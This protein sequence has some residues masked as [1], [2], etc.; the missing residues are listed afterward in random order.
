MTARRRRRTGASRAV[1]A[2]TLA[3]VRAAFHPDRLARICALDDFREFA[4]RTDLPPAGG[5]ERFF[6]YRDNGSTVLAVAHLDSVQ[7]D[8]RCTVVDTAAGPL[9]LAPT[10]DDRLGAYVILDL[11]P[12]LGVTAD[13]LLTTDEEIGRSTADAFDPDK[14]Y[15]WMFSFD[16]AG[17]DVVLYD[18]ETP[19]LADLVEASGAR[20]GDGSFS[21]ICQLEHL[22]CAGVNWGVGYRDYHSTR[23]HAWLDDTFTMVGQFLRFYT[24][25]ESIPLPHTP[26]LGWADPLLFPATCIDCRSALTEHGACPDCDGEWLRDAPSRISAETAVASA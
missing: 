12:R 13:W 11:L 9:A 17:T 15:H 1:S 20:V 2:G 8:R 19:E 10:L 18:Y 14:R 16:R 23:A 7:T 26:T 5:R 6:H 22:G 21:D 4:P 24:A 3:R 25:N